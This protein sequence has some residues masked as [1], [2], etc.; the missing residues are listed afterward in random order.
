[1]PVVTAAAN[2]N[3]PVY[4]QIGNNDPGGMVVGT[5]PAV[6]LGFFGQN[7]P[8]VQPSS[9]GT[10]RGVNGTISVAA[11]TIT[12]IS[13]APNTTNEQ[14]FA[15]T[16]AATGQL[17]A[18]QKPT[19]DAGIAIVGVRASAA[20][21][22]AITY[23]NDTAATITPTAT[24]TYTFEL[25][26]AAMTISATLT[27]AAVGPN[28][29]AEQQFA[30]NGLPASATLHVN[31][32]TQQAGLGI[33]DARMVS[34]GVVGIT[35]GNFTAATITPTAGE[36]YL[37]FASPEID[38][39]PIY[40]SISATLTPVSVAA[41]TTA[42]QTFTVAGLLASS[43]VVVNKPSVTPGLGIGGARVSAANTLAINFINNTASAITPPAEVYSIGV[44]VAAAPAAGSS[45][46]YNGQQGGALADHAALVGLGLV[47]GP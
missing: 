4:T 34:A 24:Q 12:A 18:V 47:A 3:E 44:F 26:P 6:P 46:T 20:G 5:S 13:V 36:S 37:F 21:S 17:V 10:T 30:V 40:K 38:I 22:V 23:A 27:P 15:V 1:M 28:V 42:E 39:A 16:N 41:N 31:K 45:N 35:F 2:P 29:F 33:V 8:I 7:T 25:I 11:V 9:Q 19:V 14:A 32:P 43:M